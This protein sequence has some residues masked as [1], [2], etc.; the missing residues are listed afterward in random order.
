MTRK[1]YIKEATKTYPEERK[2]Y[3]LSDS[4]NKYEHF[5]CK[6]FS[7]ILHEAQ[8]LSRAWKHGKNG[9]VLISAFHSE[10]DFAENLNRHKKSMSELRRAN[11]D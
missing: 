2:M 6:P 3:I 9:L 1:Y 8:I 11:L 10:Y 5:E 4:E 7:Q